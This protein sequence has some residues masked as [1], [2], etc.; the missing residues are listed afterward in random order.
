MEE[1]IPGGD[2]S[3]GDVVG[4]ASLSD[5]LPQSELQAHDA[6]DETETSS[7]S[8]PPPPPQG[9]FVMLIFSLEEC[10]S[11]ARYLTLGMDFTIYIFMILKQQL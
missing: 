7:P 4:T 8:S 6:E 3:P 2:T 10:S 5:D 1:S 9:I 11:V